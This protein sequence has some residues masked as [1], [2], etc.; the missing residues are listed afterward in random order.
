[1]EFFTADQHFFHRNIINLCYR[2]FK[3]INE[4]HNILIDRYNEVVGLNDTCY[5]IG[6]F[7]MLGKSQINK[8]ESIINKLNGR[9]ILILGNHDEGKPFTYVN[10]GFESVHTSLEL[11]NGWILT[12]D[13]AVSC[14]DRNKRFVVGHVHDLFVTQKNCVNVGVDVWGFYPVSKLTIEDMIYNEEW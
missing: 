2:P 4:M 7:A 9:K 12:H 5:H 13:P 3:S 11:S 14:I 1:M 8:L 6:D 10:M